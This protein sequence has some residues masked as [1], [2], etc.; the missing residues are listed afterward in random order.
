MSRGPACIQRAIETLFA[1]EPSRTFS[2]DELVK[3]V[4]R[5]VN[6]VEKKHRVAVLRAADKVAKR[7]HWAKWQCERGGGGWHSLSGRGAVYVNL[8]DPRSTSRVATLVVNPKEYTVTVRASPAADG[9]VSGGAFAGQFGYRD[10]HGH[11]RAHW[12][13]RR[14]PTRSA[15]E[16]QHLPSCRFPMSAANSVV[17]PLRL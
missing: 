17:V 14:R 16:R 7:L 8:L 11:S 3:V 10:G 15:A 13:A 2:T 5:G 4:Y 12:S 6:R 1:A 9:T